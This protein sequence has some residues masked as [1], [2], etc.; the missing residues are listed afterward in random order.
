MKIFLY[1]IVKLY[2]EVIYSKSIFS[3]S[4]REGLEIHALIIYGFLNGIWFFVIPFL[5][6]QKYYQVSMM[7]PTLVLI[8]IHI[9]FICYKYLKNE[10]LKLIKL[11]DEKPI[12]LYSHKISMLLTIIYVLLSLFFFIVLPVWI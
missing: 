5:I 4:Q 11:M 9:L 12:I 1:Y 6:L 2:K 3:E 7:Y 8:G 10:K